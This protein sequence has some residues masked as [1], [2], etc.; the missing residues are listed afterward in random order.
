MLIV[1]NSLMVI[2]CCTTSSNHFPEV[3]NLLKP[4]F[5]FRCAPNV[6]EWRKQTCRCTA[7]VPET[8][9]SPS[10]P[11]W[12]FSINQFSKLMKACGFPI[13]HCS[14]SC[15]CPLS[16]I[17]KSLFD[18]ITVFRNIASH[19]SMSYLEET[20][21]WLLVMSPQISQSALWMWHP[22]LRLLHLWQLLLHLE[23]TL[24]SNVSSSCT[25][26]SAFTMSVELCV[27]K[28]GGISGL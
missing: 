9:S 10:Q 24:F 3:S 12:L 21:D 8:S 23:N 14:H 13:K 28:T 4:P 26:I 5:G 17:L 11:R 16:F 27:T 6:K 1:K 22:T 20:I 15:F 18:Q 25:C 7:N 2:I 19:Y